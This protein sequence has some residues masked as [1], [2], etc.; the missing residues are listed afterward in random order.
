MNFTKNSDDDDRLI[1]IVN[2]LFDVSQIHFLVMTKHQLIFYWDDFRLNSF[3]NNR[4]EQ[5]NNICLQ[6]Q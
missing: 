2:N 4:F 1:L 6:P 5:S 3:R